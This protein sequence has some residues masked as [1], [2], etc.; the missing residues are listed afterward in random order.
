MRIR[1]RV[2]IKVRVRIS[3]NIEVRIRLVLRT[4]LGLNG[5]FI[6]EDDSINCADIQTAHTV[7]AGDPT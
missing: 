5:L 1:I 2:R 7:N 3:A 6:V 4:K